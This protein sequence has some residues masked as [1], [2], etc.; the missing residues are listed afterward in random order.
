VQLRIFFPAL[1]ALLVVSPV[2]LGA[3]A[4]VSSAQ[5]GSAYA[6]SRTSFDVSGNAVVDYSVEGATVAE[7]VKVQSQSRVENSLAVGATVDIQALTGFAGAD[8]SV[9]ARADTNATV[10]TDSGATMTAHDSGHGTLVVAAGGESQY[11]GMNISSSATVESESDKR[12][13]VTT[14]DGTKAAVLATGEGSVAVNDDGN[15]TADLDAQ[16]SLVVRTY[17]ESRSEEDRQQELLITQGTAT[18]QVYLSESAQSGSET[19]V[20]VV[21]YGGNTSVE[22]SQQ[23]E[24]RVEMT[25]NRSARQG[26]VVVTSVANSTFESAENIEVQVDADAAV[27]ASSYSE[28]E[29]A[30]ADGD[31][32]K[33]LVRSSSSA[34]ASADVVV[35]INHFSERDVT[36]TESDESTDDGSDESTTDG[37][38]GSTGDG[39]DGST[40]DGSDGSTGDGSDGS[41]GGGNDGSDGTAGGGSPGFT[42]VSVLVAAL[43][44]AVVALRRR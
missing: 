11:V 23:A 24:G 17:G 31:S 26:K 27:E 10:T 18:A 20:D 35:A 43:L 2:A 3:V 28:L 37:S 30:T 13:V 16:S 8:V 40:G 1:M 15:V 7:S 5:D 9:A 14:E 21:H 33:Y 41:T 19:A 6:G 42:A 32:S 39:S 38:D 29:A 36:M 4:T 12:A 34:D 25:V 44:A 22:V